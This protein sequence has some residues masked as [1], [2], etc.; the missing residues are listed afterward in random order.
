MADQAT[1][2]WV[3]IDTGGTFTD[4]VLYHQGQWR[5]T[6]V[7][8]TP[9]Q[10]EQAILDVLADLGFTDQNLRIVHGTTV[11]TNAVLEGK[12][13]RVAYITS[14]GFADTLEIGRGTRNNLYN[15]TPAFQQHSARPVLRS[16][17]G[18]RVNPQRRML[19]AD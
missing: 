16:T 3:G 10:P 4:A 5:T 11:A 13:A 9:Q 19:R 1:L 17:I 6:K 18:G 7:L 14:H 2:S 15:L 8:S 12:G